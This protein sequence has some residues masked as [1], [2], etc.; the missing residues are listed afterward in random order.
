MKFTNLLIVTS[1]T[2]LSSITTI[3]LAKSNTQGFIFANIDNRTCK[4]I[5]LDDGTT[6]PKK[7]LAKEVDKHGSYR[8]NTGA[9]I[10]QSG[11]RSCNIVYRVKG[12]H[13]KCIWQ[14]SCPDQPGG[15][16]CIF[17]SPIASDP[18]KITCTTEN[19]FDLV[20][21]KGIND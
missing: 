18:G 9:K 11:D 5:E 10:L 6:C 7:L 13:E 12:K 21:E 3:S 8:I 15:V 1:V 16:G 19:S 17:A 2:L 4:K 20:I 14:L